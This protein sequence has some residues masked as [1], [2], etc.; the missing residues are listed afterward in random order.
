MCPHKHI[1]RENRG[2]G[3]MGLY[4]PE[5]SHLCSIRCSAL[6]LSLLGNS[7]LCSLPFS[8]FNFF[9]IRSEN[10]QL[11]LFS[12]SLCFILSFLISCVSAVCTSPSLHLHP[13][14]RSFLP[15]PTFKSEISYVLLSPYLP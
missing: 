13:G 3:R 4:W 9:L 14:S 15:G 1:N 5:L 6:S 12:N 10:H 8:I 2:D 7:D 11:W